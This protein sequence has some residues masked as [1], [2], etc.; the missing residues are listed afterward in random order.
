ML[1]LKLDTTEEEEDKEEEEYTG[2]TNLGDT[3]RLVSSVLFTRHRR[4]GVSTPQCR[5]EGKRAEQQTSVFMHGA[6]QGTQL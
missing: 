2:G 4:D 6:L 1:M 3:A 5:C